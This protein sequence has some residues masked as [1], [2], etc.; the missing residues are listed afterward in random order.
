MA[1]RENFRPDPTL[2]ETQRL[3][4]GVEPMEDG[5]FTLED[6]L[7]EYGVEPS[8]SEASAPVHEEKILPFPAPAAEL[9]EERNPEPDPIPEPPAPTQDAPPA[10]EILPLSMEDIVA[11]TVDAVKED[12]ERRQ[13]LRRKRWEKE[14]RRAPKKK[15]EPSARHPLP[16][17]QNEPPLSEAAAR[18]KRRYRECRR[19]LT[20]A[21]LVTLLLWTPWV[22]TQMGKTIPFF[23][24]SLENAALCVLVP[25]AL[26][27]ILCWPVFRAAWEGLRERACTAWLLAALA[28]VVTLLDEMTLLLLPGRTTVP[29]VGGV[30]AIAALFALWG[31]TGFHH[32]MYESFRVAA[33]GHPSY[34]VDCSGE[35]VARGRGDLNSFFTRVNMEDTASQWQRLLTPVLI[36]ASLVF[37][38]LSSVGQGRGQDL[39][40]NWSVILC[41]ASTLVSALVFCVPFGRLAGRLARSGAA[42][43]GQYGAA[44]LA[45]SRRIVVTDQDLFPQGTVSLSGLKLYGEERD[46][47][48][49]YAATLAIQGGGT[50]ARIFGDQCRNDRIDLQD[51]EHFHLHDDGGLSGMIHGET[52]LVGPPI[53]MRH[54]AIRLPATMPSRTS[55][56]LA[57]DGTLIAVF[58]VKY[59]SSPQVESAIRALG[60]NGMQLSLAVRDGNI[61]PKLLKSCFGTDGGAA[62]PELS[63]RLNLSSPEWEVGGPN[64]ILYREGIFPFVDL[65]AG[66]RRLCHTVRIGNPLSILSSIAGTLLGFYLT[67]T[68]SYHVLTPLLLATYQLLWVL[69]LLPLLWGVD[70]T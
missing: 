25:Q 49:S 65:V 52:V 5:D 20:L 70:K 2:T 59:K 43:A 35:G 28:N 34:A 19:S 23:G 48:I 21:T 38:A 12:Q 53:F 42:V 13:E 41:A 51:L 27:C 4:L 9:E 40:L 17:L 36:V 63:E 66:S 68:A 29:P 33:M 7:A 32:G 55:V 1:D 58:A 50:L 46:R 10:P 47:A 69:P 26:A 16:D 45:A 14:N 64:G 22:L 18:H 44:V 8:V 3:L 67:F 31:L 37:A 6:I 39:L 11:S 24:D 62:V 54:Q 30:A 60:R 57:V 15:P 56:C 61:T